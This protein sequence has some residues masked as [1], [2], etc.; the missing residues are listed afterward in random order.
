M[1]I[2]LFPELS[3]VGGIQQVSRHMAAVLFKTAQK[4]NLSCRLLGLN[5]PQ[6]AGS[7]HVGPDEYSFTGFGRNKVALLSYLFRLA[8]R[9]DTL[10]LGHVN[11]SPL[12]L[13]LRGVRP[14]IKYWV[15]VHGVE[16]WTPLP[17]IRR[18]GLRFAQRVISVSSYTAT[19]MAKAQG[20]RRQA[21]FVLSPALD[22]SFLEA[23]SSVDAISLPPPRSLMLLTVGRLISTEPGKGVDSVIKVLPDVL[24][25]VPDLFYVI[26]GGGDLQNRLMEMARESGVGDRVLFA[27]KL[28]LEQLK[29]YYARSDVFVMPSR[30]EG[31]GIAFLEAMALGRPVV[32]GD[33]GGTPE[34]VRDGVT[35]LLVNP[36]DLEALTHCLIK[37]LQGEALRKKM[38]EAGRQ[39]VEQN[40]TF[41][42]FEEKLTR[43]LGIPF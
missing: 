24:K 5:D 33:H 16:V 35:G 32:G 17:I 2:G 38:G 43:L 3:E 23:T 25:V 8:R 39:R 15:V 1:W 4:R 12:A 29:G 6:G 42:C 11:L 26:A 13:L 31:F 37:L 20:M 7:F 19:Q 10:Y 18:V 21:V 28:K 14:R 40:Y 9:I 41:A 30:Q 36:N 27:G 22:P 34:V